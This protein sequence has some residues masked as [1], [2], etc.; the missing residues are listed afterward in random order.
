MTE[1]HDQLTSDPA[2][3]RELCQ[4]TA[5]FMSTA[6]AYPQIHPCD[7][8]PIAP[9]H[10]SYLV[11]TEEDYVPSSPHE[12]LRD[13]VPPIVTCDADQLRRTVL[14]GKLSNKPPASLYSYNLVPGTGILDSLPFCFRPPPPPLY[15]LSSPVD[16][17]RP[18]TIGGST[19]N[20]RVP[21]L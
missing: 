10:R 20:V 15:H 11:N 13:P 7:K 6:A 2:T 14:V 17:A 8:I 3:R 16:S 12:P 19:A 4:S 1:V 18:R 5:P 9:S 21:T